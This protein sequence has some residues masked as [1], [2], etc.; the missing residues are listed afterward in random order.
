MVPE[1]D[2]MPSPEHWENELTTNHGVVC[3][4]ESVVV[5]AG[6]GPDEIRWDR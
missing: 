1:E 4:V 6:G 5:G 3:D 2:S